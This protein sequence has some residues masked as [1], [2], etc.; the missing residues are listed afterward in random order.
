[1]LLKK[2]AV[3]VATFLVLLNFSVRLSMAISSQDA[4]NFPACSSPSGSL[5]SSYDSGVHGIVGNSGEF[6]GSDKVYQVGENA[7]TQCFCAT[8]GSGIQTNWWKVSSLNQEQIDQLTKEGWVY[9]PNGNAWGLDEGAYFAK[10]TSY[11]CRGTG[12]GDSSSSSSSSTSNSGQ[13]LGLASTGNMT[14]ILLGLCSG[15]VFLGMFVALKRL[16]A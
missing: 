1:M 3:F 5:I 10:N 13:V 12:G 16:N 15:S 14:Q 2:I 4:P 8:D 6:V 7:V 11:S 9:I